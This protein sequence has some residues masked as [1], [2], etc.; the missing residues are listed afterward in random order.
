[1]LSGKISFEPLVTNS[2]KTISLQAKES[3]DLRIGAEC[4]VLVC[5]V[6]IEI[7]FH[8]QLFV[9]GDAPWQ[10][11]EKKRCQKFLLHLKIKL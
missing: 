3:I 6:V 2:G 10:K 4:N 7:S 9:L 5:I 11:L 1:M 8:Q